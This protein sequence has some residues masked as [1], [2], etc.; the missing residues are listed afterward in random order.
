M[1]ITPVLATTTALLA[2]VFMAPP[3]F[4]QSAS[5]N[6]SGTMAQMSSDSS[7]LPDGRILRRA[8]SKGIVTADDSSAPWH[9]GNEIVE[10]GARFSCPNA[11]PR[12]VRRERSG[13][14]G[15]QA[16]AVARRSLRC[17]R[18]QPV[19]LDCASFCDLYVTYVRIKVFQ[20]IARTPF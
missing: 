3:V 15:S 2:G 10:H 1:K 6:G 16:F 14:W 20:L 19:S 13:E 18:V 4:A 7:E 11:R 8:H 9:L 12:S 17:W 5:V